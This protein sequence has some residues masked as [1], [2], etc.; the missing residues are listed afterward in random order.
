MNQYE[1]YNLPNK[2]HSNDQSLFEA[3]LTNNNIFNFQNNE[4]CCEEDIVCQETHSQENFFSN[5]LK[6]ISNDIVCIYSTD[7][8]EIS[9]INLYE[10]TKDKNQLL[11]LCQPENSDI[12][13]GIYIDKK[14]ER[15][16]V[17]TVDENNFIFTMR[18]NDFNSFQKY[19][20]RIITDCFVIPNAWNVLCMA[21]KCFAVDT[22]LKC[23]FTDLMNQIYM[24][25]PYKYD[26][27]MKEFP[28]YD[29]GKNYVQ[30]KR[31]KVFA[32]IE[33]MV[34]QSM[35]VSEECDCSFE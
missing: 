6:K 18:K 20:S 22:S 34:C 16:N 25:D 7:Y 10:T 8:D 30:L 17:A 3:E 13:F 23:Y 5:E 32:P 1:T 19:E 21:T 24:K 14:L 2:K 11:F 29:Q 35:E 27:I 12:L 15:M 26:E 28:Q 9:N 4:N 31:M 33:T